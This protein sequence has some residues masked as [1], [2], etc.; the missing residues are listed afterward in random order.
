MQMVESY[1]KRLLRRIVDAIFG[2]DFFIS[3]SS[4]DPD[5]IGR[6]YALALKNLLTDRDY[7]CFLDSTDYE[8]GEDWQEVGKVALNRT[9]SLLV[10]AT[11][12]IFD[13]KPVLREVL[14][15]RGTAVINA[16]V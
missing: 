4:R 10:V 5:Q 12:A 7:V 11:P 16:S 2:F 8:K 13:S 14:H 15:Q 6:N 9:R 3:Y 1:F